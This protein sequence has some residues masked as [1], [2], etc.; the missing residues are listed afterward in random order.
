VTSRVVR[1]RVEFEGVVSEEL[2]LVEGT[3]LA[4]Y[5]AN[6]TL[7]AIGTR[8]PRVDGPQRVTGGARFTQDIYLPG[9]LHVR[10]LRSP[11]ARARVR[12][13]DADRALALPGVRG[14]LHRFNAPKAAFRGEETIFRDEVR[15]VGDEVAAI[16]ADDEATATEALR[17]MSVDYEVLP[18]VVD[19][20]DAIRDNAPGPADRA[21]YP[22]LPDPRGL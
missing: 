14:V 18:H 8:T 10:V 12:R 7:T 1:T 17:L 11:Y 16:A 3:D 6:A 5:A 4:A 20:E 22:V 21:R 15:F 13:I 9:M 2:A 19:L